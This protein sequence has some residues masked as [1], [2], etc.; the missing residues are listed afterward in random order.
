MPLDLEQL[1]RLHDKAYIA[2]QQTRVKAA[3]D[4]LFARISQ[5]DSTLL[6]DSHLAYKG[7][8]DIITKARREIMADL[9]VN[10]PQIS[11][12]PKADSREADADLINGLYLTDDRLNTSLEAY[13]NADEE[14][15]DCGLGGWELYT[16]YESNRAGDRN[17]VI[18]R[19][20]V[21]EFNNNAFPDPNAKRLDKSDAK[22]WSILEPYTL[23][24]YKALYLELKGEE[25]NMDQILADRAARE[26]GRNPVSFAPPEVSYVFPWFGQ[27]ETFYVV[28][29][30][31]R[32]RVKDVLLTYRDPLGN[33][34]KFRE[35]DLID[36]GEDGDIDLRAELDAQ[37]YEEVSRKEIKRWQVTCYYASGEAILK[38]YRIAGEY[39]PVV[40]EYGERAFIE[41]EEVWEGIVRRAKDPQRL[42]NFMMSYVAELVS[43]GTV[44]KPLFFP[45]QIAGFENMYAVTGAEN[46]FPYALIHRKDANGNPLPEA[47][48]IGTLPA[49]E[50]PPALP[51]MV[52]L[53]RESVED[54]A[55]AALPKNFEDI[56]LSGIAL[57]HLQARLDN[58][59]QVYQEHR[60]HA[61]RYDAVVYASMATEVYDAPRK[62]TLTLPDGSRKVEKV[63][64]TIMD[65]ETGELVTLNDLT[66]I[67]FEVYATVGPTYTG[68]RD[69][70]FRE[71]GNMIERFGMNPEMQNILAL[72][73]LQLL[74]GVQWD[75]VK[76]FANKKLIEMGVKMPETDE[77]IEFAEQ[78]ANQ[79]KQPDPALLLAQAEN[80]KA[81][82]Q[83]MQ[84]QREA[85]ND[86][87]ERQIDQGKLKIDAF[88]AETKRLEANA[89]RQQN[90]LNGRLTVEKI[91]GQ[92]VQNRNALLEPYRARVNAR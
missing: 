63:M 45:E 76:E 12:E 58:Q 82:A 10:Q 5:W 78:M 9:R 46:H 39:I 62:V 17:Q 19:R 79:P 87:A 31:H 16:E 21:Y 53:T 72:K 74:D 48:P 22:Y 50:V 57:E 3:D 15:V 84:Q 69:K 41:G 55:N 67:E 51:M 65:E 40:P 32:E 49:P 13:A 71:I 68:K 73:Q 54:V 70:T 30:Y 26:N 34:V 36:R 6:Q 59:S 64:D 91:R 81:Q 25:S 89:K 60:K 83:V 7:E 28:R 18:R 8:F 37:G 20:P 47:G 43:R 90:G 35:S 42:R 77:E 33:P 92:R 1:Q 66:N 23:E 44:S 80:T 4:R 85:A 27:N 88:N 38:E 52:Q 11:F 2:N 75:D 56:D 24:G 61:K 14:T 29:F 86:Q